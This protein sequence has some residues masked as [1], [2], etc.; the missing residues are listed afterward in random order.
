M[1]N[2]VERERG[3]IE[4]MGGKNAAPWGKPEKRKQPSSRDAVHLCKA[5][6][7]SK[8]IELKTQSQNEAANEAAEAGRRWGGTGT[9]TQGP[10]PGAQSVE[11]VYQVT[12]RPQKVL[13]T[14]QDSKPKTLLQS[15]DVRAGN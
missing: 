14:G 1:N 2:K 7:K 15:S 3:Q 9:F 4:E 6:V 10:Q 13:K 12:V 11:E 5:Q 8:E